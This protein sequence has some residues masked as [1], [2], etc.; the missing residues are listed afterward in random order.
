MRV[1]PAHSAEQCSTARLDDGQVRLLGLSSIG[2]C[3]LIKT[4]IITNSFYCSEG[5][6]PIVSGNWKLNPST[7]AGATTLAADVAKLTKDTNGVET[8]VFPP[9]PFL[10]SV[11]ATIAGSNIKVRAHNV[12]FLTLLFAPAAELIQWKNRTSQ[13]DSI[14]RSLLMIQLGA[15]NCYTE[16]SGAFT[17]E[18][19]AE[20]LK[21]IGASYVLCGHS[22]RRQL[23]GNTDAV[24][25]KKVRKVRWLCSFIL[26]HLGAMSNEWQRGE[27][28]CWCKDLPDG[29]LLLAPLT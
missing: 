6:T 4:H 26:S 5:R 27:V 7:L 8:V 3:V 20:M 11:A 2:L 19:A 25:N 29:P 15:Q 13:T 21:D 9:F 22:E 23:F 18:V 14:Q 10:V 17:G 1:F 16:S 12:P 28:C 24:V